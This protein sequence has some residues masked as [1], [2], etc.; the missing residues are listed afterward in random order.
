MTRKPLVLNPSLRLTANSLGLLDTLGHPLGG[1]HEGQQG[2]V[3]AAT[4]SKKRVTMA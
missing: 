3:F 2:G 4:L 1:N